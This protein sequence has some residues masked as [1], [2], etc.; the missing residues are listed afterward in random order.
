M[1]GDS[2]EHCCIV[3]QWL[4]SSSRYHLGSLISIQEPKLERLHEQI[5]GLDATQIDW[6]WPN[7]VP[8][9]EYQTHHWG[10]VPAVLL[11]ESSTSYHAYRIWSKKYPESIWCGIRGTDDPWF[12]ILNRLAQMRSPREYLRRFDIRWMRFYSVALLEQRLDLRCQKHCFLPL[13]MPFW[14]LELQMCGF[15]R[16]GPSLSRTSNKCWRPSRWG[17]SARHWACSY[18]PNHISKPNSWMISNIWIFTKLKEFWI[19]ELLGPEA[20]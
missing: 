17:K 5:G 2:H 6:L 11:H 8:M 9:L 13:R 3:N 19:F 12:A 10:F 4:Q 15:Y 18:L 20:A 14:L 16:K 1:Q 7:L